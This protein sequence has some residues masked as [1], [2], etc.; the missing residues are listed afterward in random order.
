MNL[1][2]PFAYS[3][4]AHVR[5]HG[6]QGYSEY[7]QYRDW[8]RDEFAFRC[9]YCLRR[10]TWLTLRR[11]YALDHF[12][13]K[14][15]H[16][17]IERD[18]DNL[19]YACS[20]CNGTTAAR[21]LPSP[22]SVAYGACLQ[23]DENGEIHPFDDRGV[24]IIEALRLDAPEYN[25]LRRQIIE[26]VA[27]ARPASKTLKWCLG[28]PDDLPNLSSERKPKNNERPEGIRESHY[29]RKQRGELPEYY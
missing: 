8:L 14:S 25:H 23:V 1:P 10:E 29:E 17:D 18:Y 19:V 16:P 9:V 11:D 21:Y 22:E 20:E 3:S 6:P 2:A 4:K 15:E 26:T 12:L 7:R 27:E 24:T 13:P 28:Y 5:C